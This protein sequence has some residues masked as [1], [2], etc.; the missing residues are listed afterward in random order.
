MKRKL[1]EKLRNKEKGNTLLR[2]GTVNK[3]KKMKRK[4]EKW[5]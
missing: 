4:K 1:K 2:K 5:C 3:T